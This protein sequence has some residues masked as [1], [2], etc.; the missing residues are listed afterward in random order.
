MT[1][2]TKG[3]T[4]SA[5]QLYWDPKYSDLISTESV[6]VDVTISFKS[7]NLEE[8]A[9]LDATSVDPQE[10]CTER[11]A[12]GKGVPKPKWGYYVLMCSDLSRS[13][14]RSNIDTTSFGAFYPLGYQLLNL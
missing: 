11:V 5:D 12:S 8:A 3:H 1:L 14:V 13:M 10:L 7:K 4:D 2:E 9:V 6:D